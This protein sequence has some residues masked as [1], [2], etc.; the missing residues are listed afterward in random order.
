V[1]KSFKD[2]GVKDKGKVW[3]TDLMETWELE[4]LLICAKQVITCAHNRT[5]SRGAHARDDY[6]VSVNE[7]K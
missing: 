6:P 5:E 2:V 7:E 1:I 4:N 3:N